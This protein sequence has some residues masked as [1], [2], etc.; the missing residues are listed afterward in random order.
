VW[1]ILTES[2]NLADAE[3]LGI[4]WAPKLA[5]VAIMWVGHLPL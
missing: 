3:R 5:A 2:S 1:F 4:N